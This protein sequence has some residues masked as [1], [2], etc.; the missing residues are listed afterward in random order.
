MGYP[1]LQETHTIERVLCPGIQVRSRWE[2]N[3]TANIS[4]GVFVRAA[5][6]FMQLLGK[7]HGVEDGAKRYVDVLTDH[8]TFKTGI[9]Y[10]SVKGVK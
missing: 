8:N 6:R 1:N 10:A 7:A 9:F 4:M 2:L 3:G 5:M